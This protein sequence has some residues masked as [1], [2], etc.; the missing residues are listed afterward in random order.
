MIQSLRRRREKKNKLASKQKCKG[1]KCICVD[2]D[3]QEAFSTFW[4][5]DRESGKTE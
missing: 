2:A 1:K 3:T 4:Q 5:E